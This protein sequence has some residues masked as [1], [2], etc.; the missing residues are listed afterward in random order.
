MRAIIFVALFSNLCAVAQQN[1]IRNGSFEEHGKQACLNCNTLFGQYPALVYNWDNGGWACVLCDKDYKQYSDEKKWKQC[2]LDRI[3]PHD[4]KA[5][6]EM[7][8]L[9]AKCVN[10]EYGYATFLTA[11]S[12]QTLQ[13]GRVY[14]VNCWLFVDSIKGADPDWARHIGI[15][16]LPQ[17]I[18]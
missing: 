15:A 2:P 17:K 9:P 10:N 16:L 12:T 18:N 8:Y 13:V 3:P 14:E 5:M 11:L 4:G 7:F 6:I 1:L